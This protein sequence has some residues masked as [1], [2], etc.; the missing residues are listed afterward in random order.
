MMNASTQKFSLV[1]L[2][3]NSIIQ[4]ILIMEGILITVLISIIQK[5]G[6]YFD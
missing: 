4:G 1:Y 6:Q 5:V 3:T 2:Y